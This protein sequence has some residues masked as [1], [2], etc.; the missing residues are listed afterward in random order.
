V[1]KARGDLPGALAKLD[2]ILRKSSEKE[3]GDLS[4]VNYLRGDI[5][6]RM[7]RNAEAESAFKA[8]IAS[9]PN[10][11]QAWTAL[12]VLYASEG[13]SDEARATLA[14]FAR[15][16]PNGRTYQAI[17]ETFDVL[18]SPDEG[19]RWKAMARSAGFRGTLPSGS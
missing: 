16:A 5:L 10:N 19:R 8:E 9:F 2:E 4:N 3:E 18:G 14:D 1:A 6:A 12:A 7:G 15:K 11:G 13:R 17:G